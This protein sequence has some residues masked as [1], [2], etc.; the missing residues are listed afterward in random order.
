M[1]RKLRQDERWKNVKLNTLADHLTRLRGDVSIHQLSERTGITVSDLVSLEN[2][3][4]GSLSPTIMGTLADY[5][6][7][8]LLDFLKRG[9]F[10]VDSSRKKYNKFD[11][12][13]NLIGE[14]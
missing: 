8:S 7:V 4:I 12:D 3:E 5:Y 11:S 1:M 13:G 10:G 9:F 2:G 6:G 14:R